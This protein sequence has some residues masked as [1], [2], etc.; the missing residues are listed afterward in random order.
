M[1]MGRLFCLYT[2]PVGKTEEV[3]N[4]LN[5]SPLASDYDEP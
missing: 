2:M 4:N 1:V 5:V 3:E